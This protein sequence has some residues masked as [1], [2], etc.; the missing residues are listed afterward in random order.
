[1]Q[2]IDSR[3]AESDPT[4]VSTPK[5]NE[6]TAILWYLAMRG[7]Q[8]GHARARIALQVQHL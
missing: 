6:I 5:A 1:M 4:G 8:S 2:K 3:Q 7:V